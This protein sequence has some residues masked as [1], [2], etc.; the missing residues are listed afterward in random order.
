VTAATEIHIED[1]VKEFPTRRGSVTAL[2]DLS[3]TI[4]P[5]SFF[6]VVGPSG[7]GKST[8]LRMLAGLEEPTAGVAELS[9]G[10]GDRPAN[11][12]VFQGESVFPWMTV[13]DNAG[14]GLRMR[15]VPAA[16]RRETVR[17][18]LGKMR[19]SDFA[20]AYPHQLSGGMKQRVALAR[21]FAND[22][23]VLLMDEP[24]SA[25]D[26]QTKTML[27]QELLRIWS[28]TGKTVV[29]IT[30]SV[31]E[32]VTLGDRIMVMT[33]R[34]GRQKALFD[35]PFERPRDVLE[36]RKRPEYG[37][38]VYAIWESLRSEVEEVSA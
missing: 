12:M 8:L 25:L 36:L 38:L 2:E 7:C 24:F 19:L 22:P 30:H 5:G 28:D 37:E 35:V 18:W 3:V 6:V 23:D 4:E 9:G 31:D 21:A 13:T 26:E 1:L 33:A 15:S 27:Q 14:Y 10:S 17:D 11:S 34:P 29:F 16:Q 32:A 20:D